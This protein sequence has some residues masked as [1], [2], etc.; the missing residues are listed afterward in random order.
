MTERRARRESTE[1]SDHMYDKYDRLD[2]HPDYGADSISRGQVEALEKAA[3]AE[4][5][6]Q[7]T[8]EMMAS[9][10]F[11]PAGS[12]GNFTH[13][14]GKAKMGKEPPVFDASNRCCTWVEDCQQLP[15]AEWCDH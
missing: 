12:T 10:G 9:G 1:E 5:R 6:C 3:A 13:Q 11:R 14:P 2:D 15:Q 7:L 8:E 4:A